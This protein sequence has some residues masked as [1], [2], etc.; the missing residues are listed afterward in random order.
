[1]YREKAAYTLVKLPGVTFKIFGM[2]DKG[3]GCFEDLCDLLFLRDDREGGVYKSDN[4]THQVASA[5]D[6]VVKLANDI[7]LVALDTNLFLRF[8]QSRVSWPLIGVIDPASW[9]ADALVHS[10]EELAHLVL[11][12]VNLTS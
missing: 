12:G 10:T 5:N 3:E 11:K 2:G 8:A 6:I 4:R 9:K 7:D 1:M